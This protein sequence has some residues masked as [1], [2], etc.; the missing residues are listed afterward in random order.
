MMVHE[1]PSVLARVYDILCRLG[2]RPETTGFHFAAYAV[3][4][5]CAQPERGTLVCKWL[6]PDVARACKA[7]NYAVERGIRLAISRAWEAQA[8]LFREL[9]PNGT[10]PTSSH[11]ISKVAMYLLCTSA[12]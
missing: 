3:Y 5:V 6:Y 4:L 12:A 10:R 7:S 2:M 9:F 11:F 1:Q 8:D